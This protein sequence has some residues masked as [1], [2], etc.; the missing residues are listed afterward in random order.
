MRMYDALNNDT[1]HQKNQLADRP[2]YLAV[3]VQKP[4][5]YDETEFP[6]TSSFMYY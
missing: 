4:Y 5:K 2:L 3:K 6:G 1:S